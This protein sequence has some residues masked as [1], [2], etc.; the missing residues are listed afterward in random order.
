MKE[1]KFEPA[2]IVLDICTIYLNLGESDHSEAFYLA[3]SRD[4]RSYN[5]Q[6]FKQTEHVL[7]SVNLK[8]CIN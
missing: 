3:I 6:L 1:Y 2:E 8:Q 5:S 4:G 7:G